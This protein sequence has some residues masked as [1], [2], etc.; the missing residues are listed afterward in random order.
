MMKKTS[1]SKA[2][3]KPATEKVKASDVLKMPPEATVRSVA[4]DIKSTTNQKSKLAQE[5]AEVVGDA[6]KEK[7]IHPAA[8][9]FVVARL[10]KAKKTDR[11]LIAVATELAHIEY[12]CDVLGLTKMIEDQ[13]QMFAGVAAG[14]HDDDGPDQTDLPGTTPAKPGPKF[15][16]AVQKLADAT[17]AGAR[18]AE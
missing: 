13:G 18:P 15:G 10:A 16:D 11:G 3:P 1:K 14:E 2:T 12:Y 4:A 7:G 9:R 6:K 5:L 8:L 17:G